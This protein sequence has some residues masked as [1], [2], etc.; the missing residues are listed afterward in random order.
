MVTPD[1]RLRILRLHTDATDGAPYWIET[2][3]RLKLTPEQVA[4]SPGV[5]GFM[6]AEALRQRPIED[7]IPRRLL[8]RETRFILSETS[9]MTGKPIVAAFT[10]PEFRAAFVDGFMARATE[11]GFPLRA[12]WLWAGPSGPHA[13]GK[14]I[15]EI[16]RV[17]GG[18]DPFS[19]DFD[20][21]WFRKLP[22]DSIARER[23]MAH[24]EAQI[25]DVLDTQRIDVLFSTPPVIR[26]LA[27]RLSATR[28]DAIRGVHYGG[29]SIGPDDY[30]ALKAAFPKAVH[31]HG[32][33]NSL[34]GMFTESASGAD[35][36]AYATSG[37]TRVELDL[38]AGDEG[39]FRS[40]AVGET[41]RVMLSRFDESMMILNHLERDLATRTPDGILDPH[42]PNPAVNRKTIY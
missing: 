14:A 19:I 33:G 29:M 12:N 17:G 32:Y 22:E 36:I 39:A 38:L 28:R 5:A 20:P 3:R 8:E 25:M 41:G 30:A 27:D 13:I 9:G 21:R 37:S 2:F 42:P 24:L 10:E 6:D 1:T 16:L 34:F 31:L 15:C 7:F 4:Q 26:R 23:Y 11:A 35:G 40:C 18:L